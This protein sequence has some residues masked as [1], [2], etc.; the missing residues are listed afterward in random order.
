VINLRRLRA[1]KFDLDQSE[2][3]STQVHASPFDHGFTARPTVHSNLS[4]KRSFPGTETLFKP[5]EFENP[6]S[7]FHFESEKIEVTIIT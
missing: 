5:G 4:G 6:A 2:R 1:C 3:K 7:A